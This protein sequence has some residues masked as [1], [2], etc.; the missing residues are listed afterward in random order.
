MTGYA[1]QQRRV[2]VP[3]GPSRMTEL[4]EHTT[5][6]VGGVAEK[7]IV[8]DSE[9]DLVAAVQAADVAAEPVLLLGGGS[10]LLIGDDGFAGTVI[11]INTSGRRVEVNRCSGAWL[12]L[13]AGEPWDDVV[14]YTVA[15]GWSGIEAM[16]GI[17]GRVGATP[18]Q[19]V[20]AYGTAIS[21]TLVRVR[22][23]DR[24]TGQEQTFAASE[25][26]FGYRWSRF[27]AEPGR[28]LI[29][30]VTLQLVLSE[31]SAPI[32]YAQLADRLGVPTGARVGIE[33]VRD[34]VLEL[35]RSKGMVLDEQDH[36]TWSAGSFFTNPV[37]D[38]VRLRR[39]PEAAPRFRQPD[40]TIKTSAAW[41]IEQAGFAKGYGKPPATL[42]NKHTLART[43]RGG[44]AA[45]DLV[46][47][48]R[49]VR[50]G[51]QARFG[52]ELIPEPNLAGCEL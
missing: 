44:A 42:S 47:L 24:H 18:I 11:K 17:P 9:R 50:A 22:T 15:E 48:A 49:E 45:A 52:I 36:D 30:D 34:A 3:A 39:L 23:L 2:N 5:F 31:L 12:T 20:E 21:N 41:L 35:R 16:S 46:E 51:V 10:N 29:L 32:R 26:G 43:N 19:N 6:R 28:Y 8:A 37:I 14:A 1:G 40:G 38:H 27:K 33:A 25:C 4:A 7:F 13:A